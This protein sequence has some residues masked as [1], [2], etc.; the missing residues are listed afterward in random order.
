[1]ANRR[2]VLIAGFGGQGIVLAGYILG[3]AAAVCE[4]KEATLVQ[5]YGPESRGGACKAEVVISEEQID[6]PRA[7]NPEA[8]VIMAQEAYHAYAAKRQPHC[9]LIIDEDLV[10]PNEEKPGMKL[11]KIPA[12]RLAERL[13]RKIVAN[14]VMLGFLTGVTGIVSP[15]AMREAIRTSVPRG[16]EDLNLKAFETGY[17]YAQKFVAA[18]VISS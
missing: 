2:E 10:D 1:M 8:M 16:T 4:S 3:K 18:E 7:S 12:T 14:M 11:L 5:S 6:F 9:L 13:G 15:E 17:E